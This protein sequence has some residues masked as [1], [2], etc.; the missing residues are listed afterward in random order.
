MPIARGIHLHDSVEGVGGVHLDDPFGVSYRRRAVALAQEI[1]DGW[2]SDVTAAR[3]RG[4]RLPSRLDRDDRVHL[5]QPAGTTRRIR[6]PG[7]SGHRRKVHPDD[8]V[9]VE[10]VT[11]TSASRTWLDLAGVLTEA[12]LV[13]LGDELVRHPY[14]QFE[15]RTEPFATTR[16]L[17]VVVE[18][19]RGVP[20]R[21]RAQRALTRVRVGADSPQE[22]RLR[23]ALVDAGLP[24]PALQVAAVSEDPRCPR[25][26]MG[27]RALRIVIQYEGSAHFSAERARQDQRRDNVFLAAGWTVVRVNVEDHRDGF[28]TVVEQIRRLMGRA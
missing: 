17:G 24:E 23:L 16:A 20:G 26:D 4:W 8:L 15:R 9:D 10:G 5:T 14:P 27:Y 28:R 11:A 3:L 19:T 12:E 6:R 7:L 22:T 2:L 18:R 21:R 25:A 1:P 13:I